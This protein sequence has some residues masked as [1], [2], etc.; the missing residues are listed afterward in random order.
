M[1]MP[2]NA[3]PEK[4]KK[5]RKE[6]E[7]KKAETI[8]RKAATRAERC[9]QPDKG[10]KEKKAANLILPAQNPKKSQYIQTSIQQKEIKMPPSCPIAVNPTP[11][12]PPTP[13]RTGIA[14]CP[15]I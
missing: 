1:T 11:L 15:P 7:K 2:V 5:K 14:T 12:L 3:P 13:E 6:K 4:E 8:C 10:K 9:R